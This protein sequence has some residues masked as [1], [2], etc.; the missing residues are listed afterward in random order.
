LVHDG[1]H[2]GVWAPHVG[3]D[4]A[5][6][7]HIEP[8]KASTLGI[9]LE[10]NLGSHVGGQGG[11]G[12][13]LGIWESLG[14]HVEIGEGLALAMEQRLHLFS[15]MHDLLEV[16][17]GTT[18]KMLPYAHTPMFPKDNGTRVLAGILALD[19]G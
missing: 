16:F 6:A 10:G 8:R 7:S 17:V 19:E 9:G 2:G 1:E 18:S 14:S 5:W 15:L 4:E 13:H 12:P 3:I 11:F